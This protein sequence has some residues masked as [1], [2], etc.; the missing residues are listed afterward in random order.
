MDA[1]RR[2]VLVL[3]GCALA[4]ALFVPLLDVAIARGWL[5]E[6]GPPPHFRPVRGA[7]GRALADAGGRALWSVNPEVAAGLAGGEG[8]R[9]A[10][11]REKG[12]GV[13]RVLSLR[14]AGARGRELRE[15]RLR[16]PR[17]ALARA[18]ARRLRPRRARALRRPQ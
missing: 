4:A 9:L 15:E 7:D 12:S 11:P 13:W 17:L 3:A 18:R 6:A 16:Q 1:R 2:G 14:A 5:P 10:T 8:D